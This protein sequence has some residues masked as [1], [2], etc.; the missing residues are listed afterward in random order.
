MGR[1]VLVVLS[2][3]G[4]G[5]AAVPAPTPTPGPAPARPAAPPAVTPTPATG[6]GPA[7]LGPVATSECGVDVRGAASPWAKIERARRTCQDALLL[8]TRAGIGLYTPDA[9]LLAPLTTT[10]GRHLQVHVDGAAGAL[11]FF[12]LEAPRLVR[13][14]LANGE[15][16]VVAELPSLDLPCFEAGADP[17]GYIQADRERFLDPAAGLLCLDAQ[18]RNDNMMSAEVNFKVDL[19]TGKV[20]RRVVTLDPEGCEGPKKKVK[21]EARACDPYAL[22]EARARAGEEDG[23]PSPTGGWVYRGLSGLVPD[24]DSIYAL[25]TVSKGD[26]TYAIT[27]GKLVPFTPPREGAEATLPEGACEVPAEHEPR[28]MPRSPVLL[29]P[30]CGGDL[31]IVRPEPAR[32]QVMTTDGFTAL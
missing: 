20:T 12:A 11:Y 6:A 16:K 9:R 1:A 25:A 28:W 10:R 27:P 8:S 32:L 24:G 18:D 3:A 19:A 21:L 22:S 13:L 23:L 26:R 30:H 29:V 17:V 4:C 15:E 5:P 31:L 7:A 14:D 2:L